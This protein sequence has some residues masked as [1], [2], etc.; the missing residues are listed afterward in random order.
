MRKIE[1]YADILLL[2]HHKAKNR[3]EMS[4]KD[5]A[6][7]FA[8]FAALKGYEESLD[9]SNRTTMERKILSDTLLEELNQ[10]IIALQEKIKSQ[11]RVKIIYYS[12]DEKKYGGNYQEESIQM[13]EIDT[14]QRVIVST[15][16]KKYPFDY[17]FDIQEEV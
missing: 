14:V 7:Q 12:P 1:D 9:E 10:K 8:P 17:I 13:K 16:R 3:K 11:P 4:L 2:P 5:R 15:K 6:A